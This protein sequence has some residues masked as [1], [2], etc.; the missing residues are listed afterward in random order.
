[1]LIATTEGLTL[2]TTEMKSG[3]G[4][5]CFA[6]GGVQPGSLGWVGV[7]GE[8]TS[9]G[10]SNEQLVP[11][12]RHR[13]IRLASKYFMFTLFIIFIII[14]SSYR[15]SVNF[16][17]IFPFLLTFYSSTQ[18]EFGQRFLLLSGCFAKAK[19]AIV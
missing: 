16:L 1:M 3:S 2:V 8:E 13:I 11:R 9:D 19:S 18:V 15:Q 10:D 12:K 14:A 7:E 5:F 6:G 17:L 4:W